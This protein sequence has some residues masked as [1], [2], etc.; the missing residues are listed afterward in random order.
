MKNRPAS[1]GDTGD[2]G[3]IPGSGRSPGG[4][5]ANPLQ[6]PHGQRILVG[7]SPWGHKES[8]RTEAT[9]HMCAHTYTY[10]HTDRHT[11]THTANM[12]LIFLPNLIGN[13]LLV[14]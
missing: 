1:A 2:V 13:F 12:N 6:Y 8:D 7:C 5:H 14:L 9:E 4:G 10:T 11:H 3:L